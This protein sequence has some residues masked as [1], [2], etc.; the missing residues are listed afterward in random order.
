MF[1]LHRA[2]RLGCKTFFRIVSDRRKCIWI[3]NSELR[4]H[5]SIDRTAYLVQPIN[6]FAVGQSIYLCCDSYTSNPKASEIALAQFT[7]LVVIS[8]RCHESVLAKFQMVLSIAVEPFATLE[9][10]F[11]SRSRCDGVCYTYHDLSLYAHQ[12][13]E[14]LD[15]AFIHEPRLRQIAFAL[16]TLF[17]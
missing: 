16:G 7:M 10:L 8:K 1:I 2:A 3:S 13:F 11:C 5:L 6:Q 9:K 4:K 17:R 15:L 12:H 14:H